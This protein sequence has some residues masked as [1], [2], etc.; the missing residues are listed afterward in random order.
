MAQEEERTPRVLPLKCSVQCYDWGKVGNASR[1][2]QLA[3]NNLGI[4]IEAN[5][6][7]AELWIGTHPKG[8]ATLKESGA[9]LSDWLAENQWAMGDCCKTANQKQVNLPFLLKVL[10]VKSALSIQAHPDKALAERL[11]DSDPAN[12]PDDNHKPEICVA[13][14]RFEGLAGFV[15]LQQLATSLDTV[16]ELR[17]LIGQVT[18]QTLIDYVREHPDDAVR[19]GGHGQ[20]TALLKDVYRQLMTANSVAVQEQ[21][22]SLVERLGNMDEARLS[23]ADAVALRLH[24]DYPHDIG[25]FCAY[26]LNH[27]ALSTGQSF[28]LAPNEP[29]AYLSGDCVECMASSDNVVRAG[30]TPKFK[31]LTTLLNMLTYNYGPAPDQRFAPTSVSEH[32][33][34]FDPPA[35]EFSVAVV[36]VKANQTAVLPPINGPGVLLAVN[37]ET[38]LVDHDVLMTEGSVVFVAAH[39]EVEV[40]GR[41]GAVGVLFHAYCAC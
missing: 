40:K 8:P 9:L 38:S 21:T 37:G 27:V 11:H 35:P 25:V 20:G 24:R 7:Y 15:P 16:P 30:L 13:L 39:T 41:E 36:T 31:D 33:T 23:D 14:T 12:Y 32:T 18:S 1:V 2:A 34:L 3:H 28:Y 29:H 17:A 26:L 4:E 6:P 22:T 19:G 10:S 5:K